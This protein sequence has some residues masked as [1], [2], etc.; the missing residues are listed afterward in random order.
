VTG[1]PAERIVVDSM[2]IGGDFGGKGHSI[3]EFPC[4][5]LA[6][7]TGRPIK[8]VMSYAEELESAAPRHGA[9]FHLRTAVGKDG[10][11]LDGW[12]ALEVYAVPHARL[13]TFMVYTNKVPGGQMR[14][15]GAAHTGFVGESHIDHIARELG[16]DPLD[17][18]ILNA[19]REG[20]TGPT[21]ERVQNPQAVEVLE[22]LKRE[23]GWKT[24]PLPANHG[25]GISLRSRDV[26]AGRAEILIRLRPDGMIEA[27]HGAP[28]QGGGSATLVRRVSAAVLSVSPDRVIA[29]YGTTAE[30]PLN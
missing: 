1:L 15:P 18:R 13:E 26:G 29:R 14:A 4:Y 28:D 30:A 23:S 20:R 16:M 8:S 27:I 9:K 7:A 24:H 19:V 25:R 22:A 6:A 3:E 21:G 2:F 17:F 11:I 10:R 12:S 5:F